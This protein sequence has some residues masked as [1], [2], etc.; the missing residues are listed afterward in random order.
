MGGPDSALVQFMSGVRQRITSPD[1]RVFVASQ[2]DYTGMRGSYYL[3]PLNVFWQRSRS[4]L[5]AVRYIHSGDYIVLINPTAIRFDSQKSALLTPDR[6]QI[7][8]KLLGGGGVGSLYR[9][10]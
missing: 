4:E 3:Y 10:I 6:E 5:P 2:D 8:V 7:L 1:A 9:V